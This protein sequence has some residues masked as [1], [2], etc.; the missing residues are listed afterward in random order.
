MLSDN[1]KYHQTIRSVKT[2]DC[3]N[4]LKYFPQQNVEGGK[5]GLLSM[6]FSEERLLQDHRAAYVLC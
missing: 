4:N 5:G 3:E 1:I 2:K 6:V